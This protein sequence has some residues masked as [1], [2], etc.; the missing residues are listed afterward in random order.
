M[1]FVALVALVALVAFVLNVSIVKSKISRTPHK[2]LSET[3]Q[4]RFV[5]YPAHV[6]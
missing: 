5:S 2:M 1:K 3:V 4:K 6:G